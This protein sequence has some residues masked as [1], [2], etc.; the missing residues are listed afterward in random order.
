MKRQILFVASLMSAV[1]AIAQDDSPAP[2]AVNRN[3][4]GYDRSLECLTQAIYYEARNQSADGQRAVAQVVLNRA[5]H[6]S[7][8]NTVCG[9]VFQGS[10]RVTGCQFSFTCDGSMYREIEPY[11][12]EQAQTIAASALSGSV[13]R[14]V[15]LALN[16]HTT[17]IRP[18]WAPSLERQ[19]VIGAHIFYRRPGSSAGSFVQQPGEETGETSYAASSVVRQAAP[20]RERAARLRYAQLEIPVMEIPVL[21]RPL[22]VRTLG[23]QQASARSRPTATRRSAPA[24]SGARVAIEA[25]VRVAR[26]S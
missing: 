20:R 16:Y 15:G 12:W 24:R 4:A 21:E 26:G 5:R 17:A 18:Y 13:Y 2:Y 10:E 3:A 6:P 25:G 8:P 7:Y 11:A 22:R 23:A 1:P 19:A 9:V 14:P